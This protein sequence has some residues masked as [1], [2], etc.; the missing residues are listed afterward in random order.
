MGK[1]ARTGL[2]DPI[3]LA[4][5]LGRS[6]DTKEAVAGTSGGDLLYI[7]DEASGVRDDIFQAIDGNRMGGNAWVFLISNPTRADGE[8]YE[9]HHRKSQE[10]IGP[11]GYVT[12]HIS[13]RESP[14]VTG[15]WRT[16]QEWDPKLGKWKPRRGP[17][18]GLADPEELERYAAAHDAAMVKIRIE[19]LFVIGEEAK[20]FPLS[21]LEASQGRW[22]ETAPSGRLYIGL[23][24][25]GS[26]PEGDETVAVA[27]RGSKVTAIR[28]DRGLSADGR[29]ALVC[30]LIAHERTEGGYRGPKP[31]VVFDYGG[32]VGAETGAALT[33]YLERNPEAFELVRMVSS[34]NA[35]RQRH[36]YEKMRDLLWAIAADWLKA[37]GALP[38][39]AKL[40]RDLHA[41][42]F[43]LD[44]K[45]RLKLTPKDEIKKLLGRSPDHGDAFVLSC[46]EPTGIVEQDEGEAEGATA[47]AARLGVSSH[48]SEWLPEHTF[49]PY[50]GS[51][52]ARGGA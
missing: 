26:G 29:V 49:D 42:E 31:V 22:H 41:P 37:G 48:E 36:I 18:P 43:K 39:N 1:L 23:D 35:I 45:N 4:E 16:L 47:Q 14:N 30:D 17:I 20:V 9:S 50:G 10:A 27:R 11:A 12:I 5:I 46:W 52:W 19:G 21:A 13:S 7:V 44:H 24:P 8:F 15:E 6:A 40:E 3:T 34:W 51:D 25:A 28:A 38:T 32:A 33:L 2:R